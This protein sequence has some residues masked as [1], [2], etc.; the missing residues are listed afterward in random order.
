L[1][2][3]NLLLKSTIFPHQNIYKY[4]WISPDAETPNLIDHILIDRGRNSSIL[5]V[6]YFR[7][8]DC[9]TDRY[10]VVA[11]VRERLPESKQATHTFD[12]EGFILI[13]LSDVEVR[14]QDQSKISNRF[15]ALEN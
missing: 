13:K 4:T 5:D 6:R 9:D 7:R 3:Q 15:A 10:L 12:A 2:H 8:T 14:K 11:K 1:P